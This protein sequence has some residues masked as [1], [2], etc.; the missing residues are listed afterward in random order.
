M[1]IAIHIYLLKGTI[2]AADTSVVAAT[3][4]SAD[5]KQYLKVVLHLLIE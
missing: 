3:A 5:K 1:I 4:N 2:T